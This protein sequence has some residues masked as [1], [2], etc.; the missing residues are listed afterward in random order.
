MSEWLTEFA[1]RLRQHRQRA[2]AHRLAVNEAIAAVRSVSAGKSKDEVRE[3]L[4]AELR[5]RDITPPAELILTHMA[6][7][8]LADDDALT[9]LRLAGRGLGMLAELGAKVTRDIKEQFRAGGLNMD[10]GDT[11][12][13]F[14][15]FD[16]SR[17]GAPVVLD[18]DAQQWFDANTDPGS[19]PDFSE[20]FVVLSWAELG[21]ESGQVAVRAGDRRVGA[22]TAADSEDFRSTLD[23]GSQQNRPVVTEA[24]LERTPDA[25]WRMTAYR[26][27]TSA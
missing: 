5:S 1:A 27:A 22:L 21:R 13:L 6:D 15:H 17:P 24:A 14:I 23:Q 8:V 11:E 2:R 4:A 25:T 3:M 16:P 7:R 18:P 20:I 19:R 26:P 12:P 10:L 9:Q